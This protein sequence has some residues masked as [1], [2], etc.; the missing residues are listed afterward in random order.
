VELLKKIAKRQSIPF[1]GRFGFGNGKWFCACRGLPNH[2]DL[3]ANL[4]MLAG[5]WKLRRF[6]RMASPG[7]SAR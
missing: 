2:F 4:V 6:K 3:S 5:K 7:A 1:L